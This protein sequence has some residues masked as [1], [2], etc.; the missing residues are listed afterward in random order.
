MC[1]NVGS[2]SNL[3]LRLIVRGARRQTIYADVSVSA[4]PL[5]CGL[6]QAFELD[7]MARVAVF[8]SA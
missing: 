1:V 8:C 3:G 5:H 7:S 2:G 4:E 6:W